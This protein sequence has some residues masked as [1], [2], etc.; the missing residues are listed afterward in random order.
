M[1]PHHVAMRVPDFAA[2]KRWFVEKL[3][4]RVLHE[5]P[6][7]DLQLAYLAPPTDDE[8]HVE[9]MGGGVPLPRAPYSDLGDSLR[10]EGYHHV[11]LT[12]DSVREALEELRRRQVKVVAEPFDIEAISR[13]LAFIADPWG[14]LIELSEVLVPSAPGARP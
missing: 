2:S 3:D 11:C 13:R 5:W 9:I 10:P 6:Y 14:N 4:F 8:F 1:K 7:G 12:V